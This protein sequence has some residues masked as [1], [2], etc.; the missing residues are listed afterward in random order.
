AALIQGGRL[1]VPVETIESR[2]VGPTL[3]ADAIEASAIAAINGMAVTGLFIIF[4]YR[5]VGVMGVT[6]LVGYTA[7]SYAALTALGATLTLPGLAG[8]VL[9]I[10]MA[11]DANVLIFE[12]TREEYAEGR[13]QS[14]PRAVR[15][16][17]K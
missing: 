3:G 14:M 16:G 1:P 10:G 15:T 5:L 8:F 7:I 13:T 9:A 4:V 11:V 12:R 2:P 6:A 17:F